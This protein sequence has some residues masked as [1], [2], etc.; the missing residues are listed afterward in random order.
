MGKSIRQQCP[1]E[2][3][4]YTISGKNLSN[5]DL[6]SIPIQFDNA[7]TQAVVVR[8]QLPPNTT[9]ADIF[10]SGSARVGYHL[11]GTPL[12]NYQ[13]SRPTDLA[14]VDAV[15]FLYETMAI[16]F[17]FSIDFLDLGLK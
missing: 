17:A 14:Q 13:R 1:G 6:P 16:G 10:A 5:G 4:R 11:N 3:I 15:A 8:D 2:A 12:H 7:S 9:I